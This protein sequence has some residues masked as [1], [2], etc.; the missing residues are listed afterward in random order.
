MN[1]TEEC[2][3]I[4]VIIIC[5]AGTPTACVLNAMV[6][7]DGFYVTTNVVLTRVVANA[8]KPAKKPV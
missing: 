6:F 5:S 7:Y 2:G 8:N 4:K 1:N 3:W